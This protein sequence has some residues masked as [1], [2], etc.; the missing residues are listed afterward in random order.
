MCIIYIK[1]NLKNNKT[2]TLQLNI[3][4][5]GYP[6]KDLN[7][8]KME[9]DNKNGKNAYTIYDIYKVRQENITPLDQATNENKIITLITCVNYTDDRLII[10][11][12]K[13]K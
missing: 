11:A 10:K 1:V 8:L 9:N 3:K 4:V 6:F 7:I 5:Y 13:N 2:Y 12:I